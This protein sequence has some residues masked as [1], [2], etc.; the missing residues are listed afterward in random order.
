M[1]SLFRSNTV[2]RLSS[3]LLLLALVFALSGC[4]G[5]GN[6]PAVAPPPTGQV[7]EDLQVRAFQRA[8]LEVICA[9]SP[10]Y[11]PLDTPP[12]LRTNI[13]ESFSDEVEYI[14]L[15]TA[16]ERTSADGRFKDGATMIDTGEV[17]RTGR[18]DVVGVDVS[19]LRGFSDVSTRTYLFLWDGTGWVDTSPNDTGVTV[20]T[21]VS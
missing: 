2:C 1:T 11:A 17:D 5:P 13:E 14:G 6:I 20:T 16:E 10:I 8:C 4:L 21:S 7:A 12:S 18:A 9:G 19:I 15:S 3:A